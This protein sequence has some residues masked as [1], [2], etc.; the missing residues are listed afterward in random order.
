MLNDYSE[1]CFDWIT[2]RGLWERFEYEWNEIYDFWQNGVLNPKRSKNDDD[3]MGNGG[4]YTIVGH[5]RIN[6]PSDEDLNQP[7]TTHSTC[8]MKRSPSNNILDLHVGTT[9]KKENHTSSL[10]YLILIAFPTKN[11]NVLPVYVTQNVIWIL[12]VVVSANSK[13]ID[14]WFGIFPPISCPHFAIIIIYVHVRMI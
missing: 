8:P 14:C 10:F 4:T 12:K 9:I 5:Q 3:N 11:I 1:L 13:S 6:S 2:S 7:Q